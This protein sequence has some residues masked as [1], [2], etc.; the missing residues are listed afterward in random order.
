MRFLDELKEGDEVVLRLVYTSAYTGEH[1]SLERVTKVTPKHIVV[2]TIKFKK[3]DGTVISLGK[4]KFERARFWLEELTEESRE[5]FRQ[6]EEA[7]ELWAWMYRVQADKA[8]RAAVFSKVYRLLQE[9][10][11]IKPERLDYTYEPKI[12]LA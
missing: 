11:I 5:R 7:H 1:A 6:H 9:A 10:A 3:S 12:T 2:D 4:H 8:N